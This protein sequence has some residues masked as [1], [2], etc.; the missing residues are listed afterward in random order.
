MPMRT[1]S[2]LFPTFQSTKHTHISVILCK[3][4]RFFVTAY[5]APVPWNKKHRFELSDMKSNLDE[6][7]HINPI[8][9]IKG[10]LHRLLF[11][12]YE[13]MTHEHVQCG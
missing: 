6:D 9:I 2:L 10:F 8:F 12:M 7:L 4:R 5:G 13:P 1:R 11:D 3:V